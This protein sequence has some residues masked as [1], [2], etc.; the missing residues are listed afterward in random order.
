[1]SRSIAVVTV[2]AI[3]ATPTSLGAAFDPYYSDPVWSPNGRQIAFVGGNQDT[4]WYDI[5]VMNLDGTRL[6]QLTHSTSGFGKTGLAWSPNGKW[7]AFQNYAYLDEVTPDGKSQRRLTGY[8]GSQPDFSP[9]GRR[10]AYA[11]GAAEFYASI[12]VMRPD[13]S[14]KTPVALPR[15]NESLGSPTWSPSGEKLAFGVGTA[16][17][18]NFVTPYLAVISQY[19]GRPQKLVIGHTIYSADWSPDGRK[20]L[21]VEDPKLNDPRANSRISLLDLRT[22][23]LRHLGRKA[24]FTARWSPDGRR[25]A[26]S[27]YN[28]LFVMNADGSNVRDITPR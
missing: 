15:N 24:T 26:F 11:N 17:D 1:M 7:I 13:G 8:G 14:A 21:L 2:A 5:F 4:G 19:R 25:I 3:V 16:A 22:G 12:Y 28:R 23:K 20:I 9:R 27:Y 10:I 6:H 18:S